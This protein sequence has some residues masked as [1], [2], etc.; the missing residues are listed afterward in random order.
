MG[1]SHIFIIWGNVDKAPPTSDAFGLS[2]KQQYDNNNNNIIKVTVVQSPTSSL[3][4]RFYL[5]SNLSSVHDVDSFFTVD[6][7]VLVDCISLQQGFR[8]WT[9]SPY[10]LV[11]YYPRVHVTKHTSSSIKNIVYHTWNYVYFTNTFSIILTKA[12]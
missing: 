3:N 10:S 6:D 12:S 5:P 9:S 7:D 11:G 2:L 4:N 8:A 1:M